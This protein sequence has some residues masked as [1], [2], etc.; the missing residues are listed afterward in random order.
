MNKGTIT[1]ILIMTVIVS[2]GITIANSYYGDINNAEDPRV[3]EA[4]YQYKAYNEFVAKNDYKS[5]FATLDTIENIYLQFPDYQNSY[6][7]GVVYNNK[8]AVWLSSALRKSSDEQENQ[9]ELDSAKKYIDKSIIVYENWLKDFENLSKEDILI[10]VKSYYENLNKTILKK[11]IDKV[12]EKRVDDILTAQ[13]E[14]IKRLS[15]SYTNRGIIQ[16]HKSEYDNAMISY[17]KALELWEGN[18]NAKNNINILLGR[19]IEEATVIEKLFPEE[20]D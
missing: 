7:T 15:V 13:K 16:R 20:K 18:R 14:T 4:K 11:D 9:S 17:K 2:I 5:V 3:I 19:P 1:V 12:I 8:A 6:E 10:K